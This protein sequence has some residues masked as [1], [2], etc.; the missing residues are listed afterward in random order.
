[1]ATPNNAPGIVRQTTNPVTTPNQQTAQ[2]SQNI[3]QRTSQPS[4][5]AVTQPQVSA[6]RSNV[7]RD[8]ISNTRPSQ[9]HQTTAAAVNPPAPVVKKS[10]LSDIKASPELNARLQGINKAYH[11]KDPKGYRGEATREYQRELGRQCV[12]HGG[13][14]RLGTY[15]NRKNADHEIASRMLIAGF[16]EKQTAQTIAQASP[17]AANIKSQDGRKAYGQ[18]AVKKAA[19]LPHVVDKMREVQAG[20]KQNPSLKGEK[21]LKEFNLHTQVAKPQQQGRAVVDRSPR[22]AMQQAR[23]HSARK[24]GNRSAGMVRS[25]GARRARGGRH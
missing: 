8:A 18:E 19:E 21:R 13:K 2:R 25:T 15:E 5:P 20:K 16:S 12:M 4:R 17:N 1:M 23:S 11:S 14:G 7:A 22:K 3:V 10:D 9:P 6:T 24:F